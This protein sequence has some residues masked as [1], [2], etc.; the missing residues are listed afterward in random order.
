MLQ[1]SWGCMGLHG[2]ALAFQASVFISFGYL[3][4]SVIAGSYCSFIFKVLRNP[5]TLFHSGFTNYISTNSVQGFPFLHILHNTYFFSYDARHLTGVRWY[6]IVVLICISL[7]I[8]DVE[9]FF[10]AP[11][12]HLYVFFG[13][14]S[15][16][17]LCPFK[18]QVLKQTFEL[19][20]FF[21]YFGY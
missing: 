19:Y 20:E 14:M 17:I 16:R 10:H 11:L 8:S 5:H 13:K 4:R 7:M 2:V 6:L 15:L 18:N 1:W 3:S 9:H 21:I 12:G